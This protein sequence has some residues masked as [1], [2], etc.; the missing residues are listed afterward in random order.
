VSHRRRQVSVIGASRADDELTGRAEEVGRRLAEAG[1]VVVCGGLTGVMEGV[2]RGAAGAGGEVIGILP[3]PEPAEA[4]E[5]VTHVVASG[6]GFGRNLSVVASGDAVI[7]IGG[8]WGTLSEIAFA[9]NLGRAVVAL[10]TWELTRRDGTDPGLTIVD[11][12]EAAVKAVLE[13]IR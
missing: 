13:A 4:N 1:L 12:P 9:R 3:G 10:E 7:A 2:S 5:H 6:V 11:S 8:E